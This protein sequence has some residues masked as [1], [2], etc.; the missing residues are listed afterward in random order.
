MIQKI[1]AGALWGI[2]RARRRSAWCGRGW[3]ARWFWWLLELLFVPLAVLG[4]WDYTQTRHSILRN[5]PIL[6]HMRFLI[7]D[8]GPELH[9]YL[10]ESDTDGRPFDRDTRSLIYQ[11]AKGVADKKPF[12]TELDVYE[13]GYTWLAHSITPRPMPADPV[14]QPAGH[15]R[16]R[17]SAPSPTRCRC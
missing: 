17:R 8:L 2:D 9:Q 10:V 16:R 1:G 13:N 5:F 3:S 7:E 6:G 15:R 12:G 14:G 11:R 4:I